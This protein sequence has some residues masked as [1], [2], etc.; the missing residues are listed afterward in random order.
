MGFEP[1]FES[2]SRFRQFGSIVA[3][4]PYAKTPT[5]LGSLLAGRVCRSSS[6]AHFQI[7]ITE[8][9]H[10]W[11]PRRYDLPPLGDSVHLFRL[12]FI[13]YASADQ[14]GGHQPRP[15]HGRESWGHDV[16]SSRVRAFATEAAR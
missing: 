1:V 10:A 11:D 5:R 8:H 12:G 2:R 14:P 7:S 4:R 3:A 6:K 13:S 9:S 16:R 15:D